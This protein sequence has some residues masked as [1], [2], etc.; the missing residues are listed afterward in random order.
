MIEPLAFLWWKIWWLEST[1]IETCEDGVDK[2]QFGDL[3]TWVAAIGTV[4]ALSAALFQINTERKA[5]W[6]QERRSQAAH[7]SAWPDVRRGIPSTVILMNHSEEPVYEVVVTAGPLAP[8]AGAGEFGALGHN[9]P[10]MT[11]PP[12]RWRVP[13]SDNWAGMYKMPGVE[14]A[15]TD[16][17]EVHWIR[18]A[19]G[20][21]E[22][23]K[24]RPFT[25][26]DIAL[27]IEH[28]TLEPDVEWPEASQSQRSSGED[29][30][31]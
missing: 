14:I 16:R 24:D 13:M 10:Y 22:E 18:R 19:M 23:I 3:P 27:P 1:V 2:L 25:H 4:G 9:T 11:L 29:I 26:Y 12:G 6:A 20:G 7:V 28:S 5:R 15:F 17:H 31:P 8:G 21:L 30:V